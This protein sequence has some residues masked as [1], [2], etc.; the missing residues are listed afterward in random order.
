MTH[1]IYYLNQADQIL[2]LYEG[3][4]LADGT[5]GNLKKSDIN[6]LKHLSSEHEQKNNNESQ[7]V[8][9]EDVKVITNKENEYD[10]KNKET[11]TLGRI[12]TAVYV[13]YFAAVKSWTFTMF[14]LLLKFFSVVRL[15]LN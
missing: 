9:K 7:A 5:V 8:I 10:K 3:M 14:V 1:R 2:L 4:L 12:T 6:L 11:R 13:G 15:S